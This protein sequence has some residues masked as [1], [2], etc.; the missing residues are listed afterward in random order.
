MSADMHAPGPWI[1]WHAPDD[2]GEY[3][4]RAATGI[5][6]A[7]TVGNTRTETAN[8]RLIA[9]APELLE[10]LKETLMLLQTFSPE[11]SGVESARAAIAKATGQQP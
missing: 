1:A 4:I 8:A 2:G 5:H 11:G 6:V 3:A 7:L 9:A 10:A